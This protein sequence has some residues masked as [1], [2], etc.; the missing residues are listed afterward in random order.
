MARPTAFDR[1]TSFAL[2]SA[3]NPGEPHS[4]VTLDTEFNA[5]KVAIDETQAV[6]NAITDDDGELG[7]GT[8]GRA[9]LASDIVLGVAAPEPWAAAQD[10]VVDENV[11][12]HTLKLYVCKTTHTSGVSFDATKWTELADFSTTAAIDDGS[13]VT[14]KL[15]DDC[16]TEDKL[17]DNAVATSKIPTGAVTE[18][19]IAANAVT[20][21]KIADGA[22][23]NHHLA[24]TTIEATKVASSVWGTGDVKLTLKTVADTGWVLCNDGTIGDASS[25]ATRR[26]NADCQALFTLLWNNVTNTYAAVSTG[27]GASAAADWAAHKTIALTK[28]LGRALAISGSGSG[29]TARTLGQTFGEEEHALTSAENGAHTHTVTDPGHVHT[30]RV[31]DAAPADTH[32]K[33][34]WLAQISANGFK[35]TAGGVGDLMNGPQTAVTGLTVDSAG[36]G[37]AHNTMQPTA[38]LNAMVKL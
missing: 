36:S 19:K 1:Q 22:V 8:V 5:A 25:G 7:R 15:H 20:A 9:Q 30:F 34:N 35:T 13:I 10:Y 24:D 2:F 11:V 6:L 27:R 29:L 37:N 16:V 28:M 21:V 4:G 14:A 31:N 17:A 23:A 26:A 38:F 18:A 33:N 32:P 3:E 12:F